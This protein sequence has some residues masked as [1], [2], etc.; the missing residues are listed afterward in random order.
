[1]PRNHTC[2]G[3]LGIIRVILSQNRTIRQLEWK[4]TITCL[5]TTKILLLD[6]QF[7]IIISADFAYPE[8]FS[9]FVTEMEHLGSY[10]EGHCTNN[11]SV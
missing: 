7:I 4:E 8:S 10:K 9:I 11:P 1:M 3:F 6:T 5:D 2:R